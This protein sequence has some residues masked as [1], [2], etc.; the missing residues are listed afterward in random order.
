MDLRDILKPGITGCI[1]HA[2]RMTDDLIDQWRSECHRAAKSLQARR[3]D[4]VPVQVARNFRSMGLE[5]VKSKQ[6][7]HILLHAVLPYVAV[8]DVLAW[9]ANEFA[10]ESI[11]N[12]CFGPPFVKLPRSLLDRPFTLE[13]WMLPLLDGGAVSD[14]KYWKPRRVGDFVFNEYD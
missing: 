8:A 14:I 1:S 6:T 13:P 9:E 10:D 7:V 2:P 5:F 12:D 11:L 3:V 4:E